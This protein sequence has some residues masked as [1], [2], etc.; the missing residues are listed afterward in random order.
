MEAVS[1]CS[2]LQEETPKAIPAQPLRSCVT[3]S[4]PLV[5]WN[6]ERGRGQKIRWLNP[7]W[8]T[9]AFDATPQAFRFLGWT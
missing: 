5:G 9:L 8:C 2:E 3:P 1:A 4:G 6:H 7:G